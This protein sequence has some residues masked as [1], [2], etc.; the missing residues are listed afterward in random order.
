MG[1]TKMSKFAAECPVEGCSFSSESY[2]ENTARG[3]IIAHIYRKDGSGHGP[4]GSRPEKDFDIEVK[5]VE[6]E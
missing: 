4:K 1:V 3:E 5:E 6:G 2:W